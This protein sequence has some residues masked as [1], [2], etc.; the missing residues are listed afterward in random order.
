MV[1]TWRQSNMDEFWGELG[2]ERSCTL[3]IELP[4]AVTFAS[5][6]DWGLFYL[7]QKKFHPWVGIIEED[8]EILVESEIEEEEVGLVN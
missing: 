8:E 1:T 2:K 4:I 3:M 7:Y 5:L 6:L